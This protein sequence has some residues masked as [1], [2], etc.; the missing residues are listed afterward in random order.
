[1]NNVL[2][3]QLKVNNDLQ[4]SKN[5]LD[6]ILNNKVPKIKESKDLIKCATDIFKKITDC[7]DIYY[8]IRANQ[9]SDAL[10]DSI[11]KTILKDYGDLT[12]DEIEWAFEREEINKTDWRNITKRE[13]IAPLTKFYKI[14]QIVE[15][16]R[17]KVLKE[18]ESELEAGKRAF[19]FEKICKDIYLDSLKVNEWQG[20]I[21]HSTVLSK[22]FRDQLNQELI[23]TFSAEA[24][25]LEKFYISENNVIYLGYTTE[26]LLAEL[27]VKHALKNRFEL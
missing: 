21:F 6:L 18:K 17:E 22:F 13:M 20:S 14:K 16:R 23:N 26:R 11:V 7:A 12:I 1:L 15:A 19:E 24:K 8:G 4:I 9:M 10:T 5:D 27:I 25:R 2:T 3:S